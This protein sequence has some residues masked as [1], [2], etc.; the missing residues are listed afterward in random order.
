MYATKVMIYEITVAM[1]GRMSICIIE[2]V[3]ETGLFTF[4]TLVISLRR[5]I[6]FL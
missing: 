5:E 4:C 2:Q 6:L 1:S 3:H